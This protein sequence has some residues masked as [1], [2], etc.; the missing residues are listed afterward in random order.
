M[1]EQETHKVTLNPGDGIGPGVTQI[2][3]RILEATGVKFELE[4]NRLLPALKS[5][6]KRCYYTH[7]G[8]PHANHHCTGR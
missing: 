6:S 5:S 2:V 3:I 4:S 8:G 1:A 7:Q